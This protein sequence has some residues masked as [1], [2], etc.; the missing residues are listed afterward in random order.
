M[1]VVL[2]KNLQIRLRSDLSYG[3]FVRDADYII[4]CV[5]QVEAII[6]YRN[7]YRVIYYEF[8]TPSIRDLV[9]GVT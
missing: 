5:T 7:M 8:S 1:G 2:W 9:Q 4:Y 6:T 3:T